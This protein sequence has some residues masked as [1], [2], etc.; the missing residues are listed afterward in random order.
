[1]CSS[2]SLS[3]ASRALP[4][5]ISQLQGTQTRTSHPGTQET[6]AARVKNCWKCTREDTLSSKKQPF[7]LSSCHPAP[8]KPADHLPPFQGHPCVTIN[9]LLKLWSKHFRHNEYTCRLPQQRAGLPAQHKL[10][11]AFPTLSKGTKEWELNKDQYYPLN[12][13]MSSAGTGRLDCFQL[14]KK[15]S[16]AAQSSRARCVEHLQ[17]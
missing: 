9:I 4:A 7:P 13:R 5:V 12:H 14:L 8:L 2:W 16:S 3:S 11:K 17:T 15:A 1:M 6:M 10:C